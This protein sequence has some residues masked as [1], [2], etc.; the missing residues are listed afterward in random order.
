MTSRKIHGRRRRNPQSGF[1]LLE[2]M[3][4]SVLLLIVFSGLAQI[5]SRG[6]VQIGYEEDR[7]RATAILQA[8]IDGLRRD[9]AYDTLASLAGND[10]TYTVGNL[11]YTVSHSVS[12]ADPEPQ[13]TTLTLQVSWPARTVSGTVTRTHSCSTILA[14]GLPVW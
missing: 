11:N 12:V 3:V 9:Y 7:R 4:A 5:Y 14:R 8:R 10:T 13:A 1:T 6:R 2:V